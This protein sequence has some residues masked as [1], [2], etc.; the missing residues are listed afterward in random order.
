M[1]LQEQ[2]VRLHHR[3]RARRGGRERARELLLDAVE[4]VVDRACQR[5]VARQLDD[6]LDA[7]AQLHRAGAARVACERLRPRVDRGGDL[8]QHL[9]PWER[10]KIRLGFRLRPCHRWRRPGLDRDRLRPGLHRRGHGP[11]RGEGGAAQRLGGH[12]HLGHQAH[13][14]R[15]EVAQER[16]QQVQARGPPLARRIRGRLERRLGRRRPIHARRGLGPGL[17]GDPLA[18][19]A[20]VSDRVEVKVGEQPRELVDL[21][22]DHV[23]RRRRDLRLVESRQLADADHHVLGEDRRVARRDGLGDRDLPGEVHRG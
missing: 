5:E 21:R 7:A 20:V 14:R 22:G 8:A 15:V 11:D 2:P 3:D 13:R 17:S 18:Q 6:E 1:R 12:A 10:R 9:D 23:T 19:L 16:R 4:Q